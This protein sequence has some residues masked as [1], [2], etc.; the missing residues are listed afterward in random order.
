MAYIYKKKFKRF[1]YL[2]NIKNI[3]ININQKS[4]YIIYIIKKV[5][6]FKNFKK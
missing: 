3:Y 2:F 5:D 1:I 4:N 6:V